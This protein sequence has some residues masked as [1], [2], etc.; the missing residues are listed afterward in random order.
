MDTPNTMLGI[1][2]HKY[3]ANTITLDITI[4]NMLYYI[5]LL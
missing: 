5:I 3:I 1:V 4:E 2:I